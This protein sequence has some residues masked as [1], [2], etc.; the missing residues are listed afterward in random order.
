MDIFSFRKEEDNTRTTPAPD[1]PTDPPD[2][3][4]PS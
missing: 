2:L 4:N 3:D 1:M